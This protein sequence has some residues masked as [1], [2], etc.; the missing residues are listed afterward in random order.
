MS[1]LFGAGVQSAAEEWALIMARRDAPDIFK[2]IDALSHVAF[3]IPLLIATRRRQLL[4]IGL[5]TLFTVISFSYHVCL[6]WDV[7]GGA[8][9]EFRRPSDHI[10]AN[11]AIVLLFYYATI[12]RDDR[13]IEGATQI[14]VAEDHDTVL[15]QYNFQD[16]SAGDESLV[17]PQDAAH[18]VNAMPPFY[19]QNFIKLALVVELV[20]PALAVLWQPY[21]LYA[22]WVTINI[23]ALMWLIYIIFFRIERRTSLDSARFIVHQATINAPLA[24]GALIAGVA[25]VACYVMDALHPLLHSLWHILIAVAIALYIEAHCRPPTTPMTVVNFNK[26]LQ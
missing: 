26:L 12:M 21:D 4:A 18:Y 25:A 20:V 9:L 14:G 8:P 19:I 1:L 13:S 6:D 15:E 3:L 2:V 23:C 24:V 7:C 10:T 22:S 11:L 5:I 16:L 17:T